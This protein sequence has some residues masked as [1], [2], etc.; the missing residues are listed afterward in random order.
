MPNTKAYSMPNVSS[1]EDLSKAFS[2]LIKVRSYCD[3]GHTAWP[4]NNEVTHVR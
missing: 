1:D 2:V 4:Q 3:S